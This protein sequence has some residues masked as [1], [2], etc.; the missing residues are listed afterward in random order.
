LEKS[1]SKEPEYDEDPE[2]RTD[3]QEQQAHDYTNDQNEL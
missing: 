1:A 3:E 2:M